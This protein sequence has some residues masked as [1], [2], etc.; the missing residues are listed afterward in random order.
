MKQY[1]VD[2]SRTVVRKGVRLA[3]GGKVRIETN[4]DDV[5]AGYV[6]GDH[7]RYRVSIDPNGHTCECPST[8]Q[9]SHMIALL[10]EANT[11]ALKMVK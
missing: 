11:D 7:A 4:T 2:T 3:V 8:R 10:I 6:Q 1:K 5:L 9:C